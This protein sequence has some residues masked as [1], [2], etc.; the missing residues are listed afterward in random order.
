MILEE[1]FAPLA[2]NFKPDLIAV[3][4]GQDAHFEDPIASLRFSVETYRMIAE[5]VATIAREV[6]G[7]RIALVLEGGYHLEATAEAVS[8]II[9][10]LAALQNIPIRDPSRPPPQEVDEEVERRIE[11]LK[12]ILGDWW[13]F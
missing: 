10:A 5:T 3:S 9:S 7:G 6:C 13:R 2:R 4:A 1:L 11:L 8:A 12:S